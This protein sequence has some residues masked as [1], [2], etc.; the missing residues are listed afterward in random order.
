MPSDRTSAGDPARTLAL[1][2][3]EVAVPRRGP[4]RPFDVDAVV[5]AAIGLA[6]REGLAAVTMRRL[7]GEL[8]ISPMSLYTYLPGKAELVDLM[9][10]FLYRRLPLQDTTSRTWRERLTAVADENRA[11]YLAHPWSSAVS[12]AR[13]PLGPGLMAKYEHTNWPRSTGW[14]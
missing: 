4:A 6:D 10:D 14:D 13:P 3:G 7:A 1:L 11:L 12:T 8:T 5:D 9:L 2:W